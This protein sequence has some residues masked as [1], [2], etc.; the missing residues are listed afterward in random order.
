M[1]RFRLLFLPITL[2]LLFFTH[3]FAQTTGEKSWFN[4][5]DLDF[6]NFEKP[7]LHYAPFTRWWW[8]GNDVEQDELVR[9]INLFADNNIG[10]VEIQAFAL[11]M[12]AK[13]KGRGDRI[14]TYD[15]PAYYENLIRV[16]EEAQKRGLTVDMTDGSGWP[17]GGPH[18]SEEDNNLTLEYGM[19]DLLPG[20]DNVYP[21]PRA[22]RGD[23]LGA[24]LV[25][26]LAAKV[27]QDTSAVNP[28]FLLDPKSV[29]DI[30]AQVVDTTFHYSAKEKGWK[31]IAFWSV[32][33]MEK[34]ML[35]AKRD[36]GFVMNH[37]DSTKVFKNYEYFFG[38]RTG[39][40]AYFGQPFRA[41]FD[42]SYEFKADRHFSDDFISTFKKNR[43]Y[44]ITPYLPANVW[45]GYN[46]MY[47]RMENPAQQPEFSFGDDDWRLRYDYDLTLS[48]VIGKQ[49]LD[50]AGNWTEERGLLHRSQPYGLNIDN[51]AVAGRIAIPEVETMQFNKGSEGA[52]KLITSGAHLYNRPLI[53]CESAV[54]INRGYMTTPQK[55][56]ITLD[57]VF[58]AGVNH[59]V[60]HG[61]AYRYFP[62][63]YPEEGWYPF[64]NA[65]VPINFS[66]DLNESNPFWK[67]MKDINSYAQRAQYVL[68]SGKPQA[69]VLIYYPFLNYSEHSANPNEILLNGYMKDVEPA[70]PAENVTSS[71]S[72]H[73]NTEWLDKIWPL[74]NE[75]NARG[76]TWD[77][78]NDNS[79][80][81]ITLDN[82]NQLNVRG[83]CY[84]SLVLFDLPYIQL[85][86][87]EHIRD[88][89][90]KGAD[91]LVVGD[92]PQKQPSYLNYQAN[93]KLTAQA[94]QQALSGTSVKHIQHSN[95]I[96]DWCSGIA[97]PIANTGKYPFIR[98]I[99]R[100]MDDGTVAQFLWN[101]SSEWQHIEL[102]LDRKFKKAAWLNAEDGSII[103]ALVKQNTVEYLLPPLSTVFLYAS[104]NGIDGAAKKKADE[105]S[106]TNTTKLLTIDKWTVT[107]DS[108]VIENSSL[109]DWKNNDQMKYQLSEATYTTSFELDQYDPKADYYIDLG[110]VYFSADLEINGRKAG[111][112]IYAPFNFKISDYLKKGQNEIKVTVT[113]TLL[114]GFIGKANRGV[115][116][117]KNYKEQ[118]LMSQGLMGPVQVFKQ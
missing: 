108:V 26:L 30:T 68:R 57:K 89:A 59:V 16:M 67:Y 56:K 91:L 104:E 21:L 44:D 110:K 114:N 70:L 82:N 81:E 31:A 37:F 6:A 99:R 50:A 96:E 85:K 49:F 105:F 54:Y 39:L 80:Q 84:Q 51:M 14:M 115:R 52:Y 25:A 71:Y 34:P 28:T 43:G 35:I 29:V 38:E 106:E 78:V 1:K 64:M 7:S 53:S 13:G 46:N 11:V 12:P 69:D 75:L 8:P 45:Y 63:A 113:P 107:C 102:K 87:A 97:L 4:P 111:S 77:W 42:D 60:W 83:N 41:V 118:E 15:T 65:Y 61:T 93:D 79:L 23:R 92:L 3:T 72:P 47:Y 101:T 36:A 48:D 2:T 40:Q 88:I 10:G 116:E 55:L 32:A 95:E 74:I 66:S 33:S 19:T 103:Q 17:A 117:Y 58:S 18:L 24:R 100:V 94:I 109:F 20:A 62:G 86:S 90:D 27:L 76:I 98:Q 5:Y 112:R 22:E 73:I 9:E